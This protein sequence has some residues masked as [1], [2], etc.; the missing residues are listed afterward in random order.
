LWWYWIKQYLIAPFVPSVGT[1]QLGADPGSRDAA[2]IATAT[3]GVGDA[4]TNADR[5]RYGAAAE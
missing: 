2:S 4:G 1:V 5:L 3:V